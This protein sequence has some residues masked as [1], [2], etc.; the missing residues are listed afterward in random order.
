LHAAADNPVIAPEGFSMSHAIIK[1][2]GDSPVVADKIWEFR[3][4][5]V[6][7]IRGMLAG[8]FV[9]AAAARLTARVM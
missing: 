1:E 8:A 4:G 5:G 9:T 7:F 3:L 2:Q 6:S